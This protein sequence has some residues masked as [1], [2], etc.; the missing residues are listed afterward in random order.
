MEALR[1]Q[2]AG[3]ALTTT[4]TSAERV[5]PDCQTN[6]SDP[7]PST[8]PALLRQTAKATTAFPAA[9]LE[10]G[11]SADETSVAYSDPD[12]TFSVALNEPGSASARLVLEKPGYATQEQAYSQAPKSQALCMNPVPHN[13]H[14]SG[15]ST[16]KPHRSLQHTE[17]WCRAPDRRCRLAGELIPVHQPGDPIVIRTRHARI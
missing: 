4:G 1:E 8:S 10:A 13:L 9:I 7:P 6:S 11:V 17:S 14:V 15:V 5:P 16:V 12:G 3:A 2:E